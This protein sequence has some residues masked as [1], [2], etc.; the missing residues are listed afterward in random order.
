[1]SS[2]WERGD[3]QG[4]Q[5]APGCGRQ[6]HR[7]W[8]AGGDAVVLGSSSSGAVHPRVLPAHL[9]HSHP[10][11]T[12]GVGVGKAGTGWL[13]LASAH[14]K[15]NPMLRAVLATSGPQL[16]LLLTLHHTPAFKDSAG[17]PCPPLQGGGQAKLLFVA[18]AGS[19]GPP[20]CRLPADTG[21]P[22]AGADK[23]RDLPAGA[24]R[25]GGRGLLVRLRWGHLSS[26]SQAFTVPYNWACVRV[27]RPRSWDSNDSSAC[28][29][30]CPA[31][32]PPRALVSQGLSGCTG[33]PRLPSPEVAPPHRGQLSSQVATSQVQAAHLHPALGSLQRRGQ[34]GDAAGGMLPPAGATLAPQLPSVL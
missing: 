20:A 34:P 3:S 17:L 14:G 13:S 5:A 32:P 18:L 30:L 2:W 8:G 10:T 27:T 22:A 15:T 26:Q 33:E 12:C 31:P 29:P 23:G 16:L 21:L 1:M 4:E 7:A 9:V 11:Q 25:G 6:G 19:W 24:W 28:L